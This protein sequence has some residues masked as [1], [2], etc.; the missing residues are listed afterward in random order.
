MIPMHF[1]TFQLGREPMD[2]PVARLLAE[3]RRLE[4]EQRINVLE[5]G[6][7]MRLCPHEPH[8]TSI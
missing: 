7:T 1:G 8:L 5:E 4:I 2:E 3:A 6:E